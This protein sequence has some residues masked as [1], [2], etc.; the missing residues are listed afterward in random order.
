MGLEGG[1][2]KGCHSHHQY[3]CNLGPRNDR[4]CQIQTCFELEEINLKVVMMGLETRGGTVV[5]ME[6]KLLGWGCCETSLD[7]RG[8]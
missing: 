8:M 4:K 1:L 2:Q 5:G 6:G 3:H 7:K